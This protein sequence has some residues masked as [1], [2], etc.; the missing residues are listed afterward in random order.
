MLKSTINTQKSSQKY[1]FYG[2]PMHLAQLN[3]VFASE[4]E[5]HRFD[6]GIEVKVMNK[7]NHIVRCLRQPPK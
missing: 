3:K 5:G 1:I 6:L 4:G 7:A 2:K